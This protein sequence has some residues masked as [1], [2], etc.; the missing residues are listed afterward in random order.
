M[1][2]LSLLR[3][4]NSRVCVCVCMRNKLLLHFNSKR[5]SIVPSTG[6]DTKICLQCHTERVQ[7]IFHFF[8]Y[9]P[10]KS[11]AVFPFALARS[12][13]NLPGCNSFFMFVIKKSKGWQHAVECLNCMLWKFPI[14]SI[15]RLQNFYGLIFLKFPI[16]N[17]KSTSVLGIKPSI[18]EHTKKG[19]WKIM[20]SF[21]RQKNDVTYISFHCQRWM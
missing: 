4:R 6:R 11:F 5:W 16:L 8:I 14:V 2:P 19:R 21:P 3:W 18:L 15:L 10:H 20:Q 17:W 7:L 1:S 9:F 12:F 13:C